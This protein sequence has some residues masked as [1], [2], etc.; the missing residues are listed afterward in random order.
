MTQ[1]LLLLKTCCEILFHHHTTAQYS[2]Q[3]RTTHDFVTN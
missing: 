3:S 2:L 1:L